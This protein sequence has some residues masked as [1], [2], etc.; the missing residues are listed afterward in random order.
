MLKKYNI[1]IAN[2]GYIAIVVAVE[3]TQITLVDLFDDDLENPGK[4]FTKTHAELFACQNDDPSEEP[5]F[6]L[7]GLGLTSETPKEEAIQFAQMH[8]GSL[9]SGVMPRSDLQPQAGALAL[10]SLGAYGLILDNE[11]QNITYSDGNQD[12]AYRGRS[13]KQHVIA[14]LGG[15]AGRLFVSNFGDDWSSRKPIVLAHL[16]T[17]DPLEAK[18]LLEALEETIAFHRQYALENS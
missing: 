15:D 11:P 2:P 8:F 1:V 5:C 18:K 14:G 3:D 13:L 12:V 10:C 6:H 16:P 7:G 9:I 17:K 4:P